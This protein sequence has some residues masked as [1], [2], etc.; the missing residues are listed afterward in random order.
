MLTEEA[1]PL[2]AVGARV[3]ISCDGFGDT[4]DAE[5]LAG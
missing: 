4:L 1:D 3:D 5:E 2:D